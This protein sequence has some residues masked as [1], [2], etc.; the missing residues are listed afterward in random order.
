MII[1][2]DNIEE[3]LN[4]LNEHPDEC[5]YNTE[6]TCPGR[7]NGTKQDLCAKCYADSELLWELLA[8]DTYD[9]A[10]VQPPA[11]LTSDGD[12]CRDCGSHLLVGQTPSGIHR[13]YCPGC[14]GEKTFE[15][16]EDFV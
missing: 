12:H 16:M 13:M 2:R 8:A 7:A 9:H 4:R 10:P 6:G 14:A 1:N 11:A 5:P 3:A 15:E